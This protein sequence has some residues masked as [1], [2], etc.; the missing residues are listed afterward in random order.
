MSLSVLYKNQ[1]PK[2]HIKVG[3]HIAMQDFARA[4]QMCAYTVVR[5]YFHY[6]TLMD[7]TAITAD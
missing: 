7:Q 5:A 2:I 3:T 6:N 1:L 4:I